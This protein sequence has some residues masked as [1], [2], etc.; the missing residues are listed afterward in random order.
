MPIL[1][2]DVGGTKLA[3]AVFEGERII[4]RHLA[5]T[6]RAGGREWMVAEILR[7]A[8]EWKQR[9]VFE[10]CG[11]GQGS[12]VDF[13]R[14]RVV[15]SMHLSGW[16]DF[17]IADVLSRELR[18]PAVVDNDG[19]VGALGEATF[20]AARG[21]RPMVYITA[22]TGI[23]GGIVLADGV[24]RGA[25][26]LAGEVGHLTVRPNGPPC[27]CGSRGCLEAVCGGM[28]MERQHGRR[29]DELLKDPAFVQTYVADF[30]VALKGLYMLLNPACVV[31]GGGI[32]RAGDALFVPLREATR[33]ILAPEQRETVDIRQAALRS[34]SVLFGAMALARAIKV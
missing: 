33:R 12:V 34:D 27:D 18:I 26:S 11:I 3:M 8:R 22:S 6:D 7:Q 5:P 30:A 19:N 13:Y 2:V 31:I 17:P 20:G 16:T 4:A 24:Y 14:Q 1:A 10:R 15:R 25:S 9:Y 32:S 29:A 23:G 21:V 28:A